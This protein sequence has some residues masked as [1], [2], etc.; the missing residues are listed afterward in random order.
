M[1][2]AQ[3]LGLGNRGRRALFLVGELVLEGTLHWH[4]DHVQ[5]P[6][7]SAR[8]LGELDRGRDHLLADRAEFQRHQ[9]AGVLRLGESRVLVRRH[10][11]LE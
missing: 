2:G 11:A 5:G 8:F 7:R 6:D 1:I 3:Q 10:H 4:A 9:N